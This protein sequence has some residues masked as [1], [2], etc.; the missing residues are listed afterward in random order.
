MIKHDARIGMGY[1]FKA[2]GTFEDM[3]FE[4]ERTLLQVS[5][6]FRRSHR[7]LK[8]QEIKPK[9]LRIAFVELFWQCEHISPVRTKRY[10]DISLLSKSKT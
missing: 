9:K 1:D 4:K 2:G 3:T 10:F 5:E 7:S 6:N 8:N